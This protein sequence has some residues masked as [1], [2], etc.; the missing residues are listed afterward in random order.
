VVDLNQ[1]QRQ[2]LKAEKE[3]LKLAEAKDT[4]ITRSTDGADYQDT[5]PYSMGTLLAQQGYRDAISA[6]AGDAV[7]MQMNPFNAML[8]DKVASINNRN[9]AAQ[10]ANKVNSSVNTRW[11]KSRIWH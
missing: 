1:A 10:A 5:M 11:H 8:R 9:I 4:I 2:E 6:G 3:F 7:G